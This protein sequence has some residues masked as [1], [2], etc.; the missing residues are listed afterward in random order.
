MADQAHTL[1][2]PGDHVMTPPPMS[3][4]EFENAINRAI[5][6]AIKKA[7]SGLHEYIPQ[8]VDQKIA[9]E[10]ENLCVAVAAKVVAQLEKTV[11]DP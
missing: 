4:G 1:D 6:V 3:Q 10:K 7:L 9:A 2:P 5:E 11:V 8:L